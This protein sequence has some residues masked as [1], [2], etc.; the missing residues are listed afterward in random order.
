MLVPALPGN[1]S[2]EQHHPIAYWAA[3]KRWPRQYLEEGKDMENILAR[4]RSISSR[5]KET[6]ESAAPSSTNQGEQKSG[7]QK[8]AE[9]K[10]P[11]YATV[12]A[13]KGV[14]MKSSSPGVTRASQGW[15][16]DMLER[17]QTYPQDTLFREDLFSSTCESVQDRNET[18]VIW[19]VALLIVPSAEVLSIRGA[20]H[21]QYLID[22]VNEGWNNSITITRTRPQPDFA[23]GF[24]REAR[25]QGRH[26]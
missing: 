16:K 12:L 13:T 5:S 18:R 11:Q 24:R 14:M 3:N 19:D 7:E 9:Y 20:T 26:K 1:L 4:K 23:V 21:L 2:V 15:C 17:Q 8:S 10:K 6:S 22:S 25:S